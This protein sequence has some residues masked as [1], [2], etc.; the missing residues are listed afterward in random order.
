MKT[1]KTSRFVISN[2]SKDKSIKCEKIDWKKMV[3]KMK[4]RRGE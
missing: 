3:Q 2:S 4:N 1:I